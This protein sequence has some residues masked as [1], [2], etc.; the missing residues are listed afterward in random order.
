M[1]K[2]NLRGFRKLNKKLSYIF[3]LLLAISCTYTYIPPIPSSQVK[4]A[5]LA[6]HTSEGLNLSEGNLELKLFLYEVPTENW[7]AVQWFGSSGTEV[8]SDS[9]WITPKNTA[10]HL[11]FTLPK[12]II[13][14]TGL[15][16]AVVSFQG[17]LIRQFALDI[18]GQTT[19]KATGPAKEPADQL[20]P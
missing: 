9:K 6:L 7:L 4:K 12:D 19:G 18:K 3:L 11:T 17:K 2:I 14:K 10:R 20:L 8:A 15:W 5:K 16:R 13:L 1:E